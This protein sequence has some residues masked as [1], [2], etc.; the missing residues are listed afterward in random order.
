MVGRFGST[1]A[2]F[3]R[4]R[5]AVSGPLLNSVGTP[6]WANRRW[7]YL[8]WV[9]GPMGANQSQGPSGPRVG[10]FGS[11]RV[12]FDR[13]R[14]DLLG[15]LANLVGTPPWANR[16]WNYSNPPATSFTSSIDCSLRRDRT[17]EER[18]S[19]CAVGLDRQ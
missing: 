19:E 12:S 13:A 7:K 5:R 3:D 4:P 11:G 16:R 10:R 14:R 15:P 2:P 9:R 18:S 6:P 1:R 8:G 17:E